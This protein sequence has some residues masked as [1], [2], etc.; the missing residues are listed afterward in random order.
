MSETVNKGD[1]IELRGFEDRK[2]GEERRQPEQRQPGGQSGRAVDPSYGG[3]G[4]QAEQRPKPHPPNAGTA[5]PLE[6]ILPGLKEIGGS[7]DSSGNDAKAKMDECPGEKTAESAAGGPTHVT[8]GDEKSFSFDQIIGS[9]NIQAL[10]GGAPGL[11]D[12]QAPAKTLP[13]SR[14]SQFFKQE[15]AGGSRRSSLHDELIGSNILK[16]INGEPDSQGPTIK[17][18]SPQADERYFAPI[19]PAAQTRTLNNPILEMINKSGHPLPPPQG[20]QELEEGLR[21][22][23]GIQ[24]AAHGHPV[25]PGQVGVQGLE[26]MKH[27][28]RQQQGKENVQE[29]ADNMSA[30]KKLVAMVE[31]Q[32]PAMQQNV[33]FGSSVIRPSP[34]PA[35]LPQNALTEQDILEQM[36]STSSHAPSPMLRTGGGPPLPPLPPA[37]MQFLAAHPVNTELLNRPE[38]E[39]L[40]LGLNSGNI[41]LE[42]ILQQ[43]SNPALQQRQRDLLLSVLKVKT[44]GGV[45]RVGVPVPTMVPRLSPMPVVGGPEL[46]RVSPTPGPTPGLMQ[47]GNH[48]S[49][50]PVPGHPNARVP[51]PHEMTVLTQ[52]IMQQALIKRKLEEQKENYRKRQGD[53]GV[54]S[55]ESPMPGAVQLTGSSGSGGPTLAFTPTSVMRKTAAERKDSEPKAVP[56]LKVTAHA[57]S[58]VPSLG[59]QAPPSPGRAITGKHR[60]AAQP[61]AQPGLLGQ[62]GV[63]QE[64]AEVAQQLQQRRMSPSQVLPPPIFPQ[65][66]AQLLY[67]QNNL[68]VSHSM[69]S[70]ANA[71]AQQQIATATMMSGGHPGHPLPGLGGGLGAGR[72]PAH[73]AQAPL[74][75]GARQRSGHAHQAQHAGGAAQQLA[76]AQGL[77]RFFSPEVLAAV[78]TGSAPPM[79]PLPTQ[80]VLTLE[81]LERQAASAVRI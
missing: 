12:P 75:P 61:P 52:H 11:P 63:G 22:H 60:P 24:M 58:E 14:F 25:Q 57:R 76:G 29:Q 1:T 66:P 33:P 3:Q 80:K 47:A 10:L 27:L 37:V 48:L 71:M 8:K 77:A 73:L 36:I 43:L 54:P 59:L 79:P 28:A 42:N 78:H 13:Q 21:R 7:K 50:S 70:Q 35:S 39:Q 19:S 16:E 31:T 2:P 34:L 40:M 30:F 15:Q 32:E 5:V 6:K 74:S 55:G 46:S 68:P 56:E 51:S 4:K 44:M 81:E 67:L 23:L 53:D 72:H 65:H 20:V 41:T 17:I 64:Q 69:L 62:L 9:M 45:G 38:A 49:V 26:M 18:P